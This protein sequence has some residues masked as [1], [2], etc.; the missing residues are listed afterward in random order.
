LF[1]FLLA[2]L[3]L[4]SLIGETSP[5]AIKAALKRLRTGSS[6]YDD[7][8]RDTMERIEGQTTDSQ[9]LAK[10]VLSWITCAKRP[11]TTLELQHALAV[12]TG[13]PKLDEENV[14][15]IEDMVSICAGIVTVDEENAIIHLVHYTTR[16]YFKRTQSTWFP[17]AEK[18][19][20][21]TCIT[22]LSFN[23]FESGFCRTD[24]EL[25]ARLQLNPLYYYAARN[26]GHHARVVSTEVEQLVLDFLES[27]AKVSGCSQVIMASRGYPNYSQDV[28]MRMAGLH[29]A[30][31]FGLREATIALLKNEHDLEATDDEYDQTPLSWAIENGHEAVVGL[32]LEK[33][34]K[35]NYQYIIYVS[36]L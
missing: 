32:L 18:D 33:G 19:I 14:P 25:E 20:A 30:A 23:T 22:Y 36:E 15:G 31:Y 16:E 27:E 26:W 28:P 6:A 24:R 9:E 17:N 21:T 35:T 34:A 1:R 11:L 4:G 12:E 2:Q 7:T 13:E 10:Q 5:K 3:H 29:L 8:Y